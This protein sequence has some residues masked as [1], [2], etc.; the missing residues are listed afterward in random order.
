MQQ[1]PRRALTPGRAAGLGLILALG[2]LLAWASWRVRHYQAP[3]GA[4]VRQTLGDLDLG[5]RLLA[6]GTVARR[7]FGVDLPAAGV[8]PLRLDLRNRGSAPVRIR[9]EQTF[10]V[11]SH[12]LARPLLTAWEARR[13]LASAGLAEWTG[14]FPGAAEALAKAPDLSGFA[15]GLA[16][17]SATAPPF[18]QK[19][20]ISRWLA[21]ILGLDPHPLETRLL[22]DLAGHLAVNPGIGPGSAGEACL[23]FPSAGGDGDGASLRLALARAGRVDSLSLPLRAESGPELA[24]APAG[25]RSAM[26]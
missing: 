23:F 25:H 4:D 1:T 21:A 9:P 10:L 20:G 15:L 7:D 5:V 2:G 26:R 17:R 22:R 16:L 11:D 24:P 12:G 18:D 14:R 8:V 3:P 6:S 19:T 13:R